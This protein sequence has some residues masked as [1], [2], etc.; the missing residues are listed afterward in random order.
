MPQLGWAEDEGTIK[1]T[2]G[3]GPR[4]GYYKSRDADNGAWYG[5]VQARLRLGSIF[6]IEAAAD[7]RS[8]E[9][10]KV[11]EPGLEGN[12]RQHSYPLTASALIFLPILPHFSPYLVGG[13]GWYFTKID[14]SPSLESLGFRDKTTH[15]FGWHVGGG[16]E[17][18]ITAN[19]ALNADIRYIFLDNKFGETGS[20]SLSRNSKDDGWVGTGAVMFYF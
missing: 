11:S 5:G 12:I 14:Y 7:Y 19:V 17:L 9:T 6:G 16:L 4:A 2:F 13:G 18:P 15:I 10:F 1:N 20:T 8:K 3:I